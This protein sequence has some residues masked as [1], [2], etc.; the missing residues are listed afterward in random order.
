M[1]LLLGCQWA[2][3]VAHLPSMSEQ[4]EI[5]YYEERMKPQVLAMFREEYEMKERSSN[6]L[7][8]FL[9]I[10]KPWFPSIDEQSFV[11]FYNSLYE[12]PLQ[13]GKCIPLVAMAGDS[14]V[15][16]IS[17]FYWPYT[18]NDKT[19]LSL[20]TGNLIVDKNYRSRGIFSQLVNY[21]FE[22]ETSLKVDFFVTFPADVSYKGFVHNKW[23]HI[24][25]MRWYVRL[26]NPLAIFFPVGLGRKFKTEF[27][28]ISNPASRLKLSEDS[29]FV[30]WKHQLKLGENAHYFFSAQVGN[31]KRIT[32]EMTT[33]VRKRI[34]KELVI[35]K[36]YFD[37]DTEKQLKLALK[38][39]LTAARR[40]MAVTMVSIAV[41]EHLPEPNYVEALKVM[42][43]RGIDK[44]LHV[45]IKPLNCHEPLIFSPSSWDVGRADID[46]W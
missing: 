28:P 38:Q 37:P 26:V 12:H 45:V 40:S 34:I 30:S 13:K 33:Q 9:R 31:N 32:F 2:S 11:H 8:K 5:R 17:F 21:V 36:V 22:K 42:G 24:F 14:V 20:Q 16:F 10:N 7:F 44:F 6:R 18:Y 29:A 41:N 3:F 39:L 15:G 23:D 1:F 43:F 19:Y 46:T 4:I 25:D 35:G 27:L